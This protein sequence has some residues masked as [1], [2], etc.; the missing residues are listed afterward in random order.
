MALLSPVAVTDEPE[1]FE[2]SSAAR[3]TGCRASSPVAWSCCS[4]AED[5]ISGPP[6]LCI[7]P[8]V[9]VT[10]AGC[11]AAVVSDVRTTSPLDRQ[12]PGFSFA[13]VSGSWDT[14]IPRASRK[15]AGQATA[16]SFL[17][18]RSVAGLQVGASP[19]RSTS[20]IT[21]CLY[22][23]CFL[24]FEH[25]IYPASTRHFAGDPQLPRWAVRRSS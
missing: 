18:L 8:I 20:I 10:P 19:V 5:V 6:L 3:S 7:P 14:Q 11:L 4:A 15:R 22:L 16:A 25:W 24:V 17:A 23:R 9:A 21:K 2:T 1:R 12:G 13:L